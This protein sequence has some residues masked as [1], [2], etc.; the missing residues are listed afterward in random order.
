MKSQK[1]FRHFKDENSI[2]LLET[3]DHNG[4]THYVLSSSSYLYIGYMEKAAFNQIINYKLETW[5]TSFCVFQDTLYFG[6]KDGSL[7][8]IS[9]E[10]AYNQIP[11]KRVESVDGV[12]VMGISVSDKGYA[13]LLYAICED[14][15]VKVYTQAEEEFKLSK[16]VKIDSQIQKIVSKSSSP[17]QKLPCLMIHPKT[18]V[19]FPLLL[20]LEEIDK[21]LD[22]TTDYQT[23]EKLRENVYFED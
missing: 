16:S 7:V 11:F 17:D 4:K 9:L 19:T 21:L 13:K 20:T 5:A 23:L 8:F 14:S 18:S 22:K 15:S 2:Y 12:G 10:K 1:K 6:M 3:F